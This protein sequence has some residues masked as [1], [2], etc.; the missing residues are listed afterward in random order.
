MLQG[1]VVR[2]TTPEHEFDVPYSLEMIKDVRVTYAQGKKTVFTKKLYNC[3]IENG[4][5]YIALTQEETLMFVPNKP[6]EI[7]LKILLF[8]NKVVVSE[9]PILLRVVDTLN[10]EVM[11]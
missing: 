2:G 3:R 10:E 8:N 9:E 7:E 4:K 11:G 1:I 5:V 6:L